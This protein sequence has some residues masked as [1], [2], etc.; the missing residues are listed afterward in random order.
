ML[1]ITQT[2][3]GN[4]LVVEDS[5]NPD[6]TPF[7]VDAAG[8]V[9]IGGASAQFG[10]INLSMFNSAAATTP[11]YEDFYKD[12]AGAIVNS[13][14]GIGR[15]RFMGYDGAGYITAAQID[16]LVDGTPGTNDMP[17]RLVFYTT[18]DGAASASERMRINSAGNVGIGTNSP[19]VKL[20]ISATD[21]VL[22]PAGTTG[23]QPTGA[24]GMLRFNT[25]NTSFEGYNGTA[26]GS[27]GGGA[28]GGGTDQ[29]FYQNGQTVTTNYTIST[30]YNAGTFGPVTINSGVTVTIPSGSTWTVV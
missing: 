2:G 3:A 10:N 25:T 20:A 13:G 29:I 11:A 26:W 19:T 24:A 28:T 9:L 17:G 16:G 4:A 30:N 8:R 18:A 7:V 23:Q 27:I 21:A 1:R 15:I 12:R 5:T 6:S 22:I 14:D